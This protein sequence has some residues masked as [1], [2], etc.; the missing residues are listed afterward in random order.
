IPHSIGRG[1]VPV[2]SVGSPPA[3]VP[4]GALDALGLGAAVALFGGVA[5]AVTGLEVVLAREGRDVHEEVGAAV[6]GGDEAEATIGVP[7][8]DRA[9]AAARAAPGVAATRSTEAPARVAVTA[10]T[11]RRGPTH[12]AHITPLRATVAG[13]D[14]EGHPV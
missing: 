12:E 4:A 7:A 1:R 6:V 14:V 3:S 8:R 2:G 11:T 9:L 5:D 10:C 13:D